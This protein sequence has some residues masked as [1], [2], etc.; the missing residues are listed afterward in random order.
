M[1]SDAMCH[2]S[3]APARTVHDSVAFDTPG[4]CR[5]TLALVHRMAI[6]VFQHDPHEDA[7]AL[8][9]VLRDCGHRLRVIRLHAGDAVPPDL[10]DTD[11]VLALGG[12]MNVDQGAQFPWLAEEMTFL[13]RCVDADKPVVGVCLGA[14]L[15]AASLGGEVEAGEMYEFGWHP[16]RL[17]FPGTIDPVY[18]GIRW[19][20]PQFH[21][22]GQAVSTL[23]PGATP[24]AGSKFC[25]TQAFRVGLRAYGIQYHFEWTRPHINAAATNVATQ[26]PEV[27]GE[28]A[29]KQL[30]TFYDEYRRSGDR[31]CRNLGTLLY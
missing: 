18:A 7:A 3:V 19:E 5:Q 14:Q 13:K 21:M 20:S 8:G 29:L 12:P 11:G 24:L 15:L 6:V 26:A 10:R 1:Q 31:F 16:V 4:Q 27:S 22:H 2:L 9:T 17:A 25:R 23:P 28:D 30:D